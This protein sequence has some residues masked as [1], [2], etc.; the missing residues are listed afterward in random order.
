MLAYDP[1]RSV[2]GAQRLLVE[3]PWRETERWG[4][5]ALVARAH[6]QDGGTAP[7]QLPIIMGRAS[8]PTAF[9]WHQC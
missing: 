8:A 2:F 7:V 3:R 6:V 5:H 1:R 4:G 9:A